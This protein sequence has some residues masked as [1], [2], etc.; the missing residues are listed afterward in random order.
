MSLDLARLKERQLEEKLRVDPNKR[1]Q[2]IGNF[3]ALNWWYSSEWNMARLVNKR[4]YSISLTDQ[5]HKRINKVEVDA[6]GQEN[7]LKESRRRF[8]DY[9]G[10]PKST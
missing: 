10:G 1:I 7:Q 6:E 9:A 4:G 2:S 5:C 8:L 3:F